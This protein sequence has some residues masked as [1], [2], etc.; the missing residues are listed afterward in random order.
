MQ[1]SEE[2]NSEI[3]DKGQA[4][5]NDRL[6]AILEPDHNNEYDVIHVDTGDYAVSRRI[7]EATRVMT[8][9]HGIDGR[10]LSIRIGPEPEYALAARY[11]QAAR[12]KDPAS[13]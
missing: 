9:R 4:I 7:S 5:Y 11:L 8:K 12:S 13:Q 2:M 3:A 6:R 10:L 1:V